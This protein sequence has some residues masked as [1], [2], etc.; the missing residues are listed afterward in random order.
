LKEINNMVKL[1]KVNRKDE[2]I[3][4]EDKLKCHLGR[5]IL[6]RA[7]TIFVFNSKNQLLIQKRSK[8]KLLWPLVWEASCSSHP[9]KGESH[10]AA[11]KKRLKK[12]LGFDCGL[13]FLD[14]FEYRVKYKNIGSEY[15]ICALLTG[16][17]N[18]KVKPNKKEVADWKW[19]D[20]KKL[21]KDIAKKSA[22]YAPWL[23]IALKEYENCK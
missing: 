18:G 7:F 1:V 9:V 4:L 6:H 11:G 13:K 5:G 3:G 19:V 2:E 20:L 23:K 8:E 17:Y 12:E 16:R 22:E 15:E 21:K 10:I 14:K